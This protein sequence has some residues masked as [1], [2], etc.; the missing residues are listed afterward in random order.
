MTT[1]GIVRLAAAPDGAAIADAIRERL[2]GQAVIPDGLCPAALPAA[3]DKAVLVFVLTDQALA[4]PAVRAYAAQAAGS[5]FPM[6]P[7]PPARDGF[8]FGSLKGEFE[9]LG[10][11]NAVAWDDGAEPGALVIQA[12]R[13]YLGLEP[14]KRDCR[15][16]ISYRRTDGASAA[17][18]IYDHFGKQG[19]DAFLDTQDEAIEPGEAFQPRIHQAIPEKDFLLLIDSPDAASSKW[20]REEVSVALAN[21]VA[22]LPVR[23]GYF[24]SD[25]APA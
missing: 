22:I 7:V 12:I 23:V 5:R 2:A 4:D 17:H 9:T 15:L 8:D 14:F 16:F 19:F 11:L 20:V 10:R 21:R 25:L 24:L 13:R 1:K 18:A 6:L 3:H